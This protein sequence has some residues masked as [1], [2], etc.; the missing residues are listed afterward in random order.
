VAPVFCSGN[1]SGD[2][3]LLEVA[4]IALAVQTQLP[5]SFHAKLHDD[6]QQLLQ[7]AQKKQW[8]TH[9]FR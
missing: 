6:E 1:T 9:G 5:D 3:H 4:K 7:L 2:I 8:L